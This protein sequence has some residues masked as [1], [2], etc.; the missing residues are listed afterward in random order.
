MTL[1]FSLLT[2]SGPTTLTVAGESQW[3]PEVLADHCDF[4]IDPQGLVQL[5][6]AD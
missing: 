2:L 5:L 3:F 6:L 4:D 1:W